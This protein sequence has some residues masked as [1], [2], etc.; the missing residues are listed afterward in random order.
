[1]DIFSW[2]V[3]LWKRS[4]KTGNGLG[5]YH[6]FSRQWIDL[7]ILQVTSDGVTKYLKCSIFTT[8]CSLPYICHLFVP[9]CL[10]TMTNCL[11]YCVNPLPTVATCRAFHIPK[12]N[13]DS[14]KE[15]IH[16]DWTSYRN[17]YTTCQEHTHYKTLKNHWKMPRS[18]YIHTIY[19]HNEEIILHFVQKSNIRVGFLPEYSFMH[20]RCVSTQKCNCSYIIFML[21][22]Q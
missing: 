10:C 2:C 8:N 16:I 1:M 19:E 14:S 18:R 12:I 7:N 9:M 5:R 6:K 13:Y 22:G 3:N 11:F 21:F 20:I 17:V 4:N 15:R